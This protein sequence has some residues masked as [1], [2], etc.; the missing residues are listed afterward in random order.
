MK[1]KLSNKKDLPVI[2]CL[3]KRTGEYEICFA[4]NE[5]VDELRRKSY[6]YSAV[7]LIGEP[8]RN[9][10]V[11]AVIRGIYS[12]SE[13]DAIKTHQLEVLTGEISKD[14]YADEWRKFN[15]L[16]EKA[17][18]IADECAKILDTNNP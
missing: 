4:P 13:E 10:I 15:E 6:E 5:I 3:N 1:K 11:N 7:D 16:R 8:S 12:Q 14:I 9:N 17:K 2:C 18:I